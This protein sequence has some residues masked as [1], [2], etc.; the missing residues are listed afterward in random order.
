MLVCTRSYCLPGARLHSSSPH[1]AA[2]TLPQ[3]QLHAPARLFHIAATPQQHSNNIALMQ[4]SLFPQGSAR[5]PHA[6]L[7]QPPRHSNTALTSPLRSC[8]LSAG[9]QSRFSLLLTGFI[10]GK[11]DAG[12]LEFLSTY[13]HGRFLTLDCSKL[14]PPNSRIKRLQQT[15]NPKPRKSLSFEVPKI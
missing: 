7:T 12:F 2:P 9:D 5:S 14:K 3:K 15:L 11:Q 10:H 1:S 13:L 6:A 8:R 4:P